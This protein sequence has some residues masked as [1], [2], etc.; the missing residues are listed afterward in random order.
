MGVM[1]DGNAEMAA[2]DVAVVGG[3]YA[4]L[5]AA[6]YLARGRRSVTVIDDGATRNRFAPHAHA[7]LGHDGQTPEAIRQAGV[8][9]VRSYP[10]VRLLDGRADAIR[11][12]VGD[13]TVSGGGFGLKA[14]RVILA[15]GMRD[16]LDDIPGLAE[17]WGVSAFQCPYCHGY[18][19]ADQPTGLLMGGEGTADH[20]LFLREWTDDLILFTNGEPLSQGD[21]AR[22]KQAEIAIFE[23]RISSLETQG[24]ALRAIGLADGTRIAREVLYVSSKAEPASDLGAQLGCAAV[25][26]PHGPYLKVDDDRLTSVPGVFAVGDISRPYFGLPFA[27]A[28]GAMAGMACHGELADSHPRSRLVAR[29]AV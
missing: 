10:N 28:D 8:K 21:R 19:V 26:G 2:V 6:L 17:A 15:Y 12:R 16:V 9:D 5:S 11:G 13:F 18:E 29:E 22:L 24:A 14:R 1:L 25:D 4:G 3:S 20:A 27:I 7:L 23:A